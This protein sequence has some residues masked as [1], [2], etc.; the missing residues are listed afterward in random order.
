MTCNYCGFENAE[1][2]LKCIKCG[3]VLENQSFK[4]KAYPSAP[5]SIGKTIGDKDVPSPIEKQELVFGKTISDTGHLAD[6]DLQE[7]SDIYKDILQPCE[8]C[9][10]PNPGDAV[11]CANCKSPVVREDANKYNEQEAKI[12]DIKP[13]DTIPVPPLHH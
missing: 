2:A 7:Q 3:V 10:F 13:L 5:G 9:G 6:A 4:V 11:I 8:K 1:N 12:I